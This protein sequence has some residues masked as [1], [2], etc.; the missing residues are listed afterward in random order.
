MLQLRGIS[1]NREPHDIDIIVRQQIEL[2]NDDTIECSDSEEHVIL[3]INDII[4]DFLLEREPYSIEIIDGI[5]CVDLQSTI[6]AKKRYNTE[7]HNEDLKLILKT[8]DAK[9]LKS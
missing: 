9:K 1:V 7:K 8:M 2:T 5:P 6:N 3:K 4:V